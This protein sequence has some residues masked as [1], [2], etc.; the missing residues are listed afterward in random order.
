MTSEVIRPDQIVTMALFMAVL[1]LGWLVVK[2]NK[3]GL[4]R[5]IHQG[6]RLKL[7]EVASLSPTD[8][9]MILEA[10]GRSFLLIRCKGAAPVIQ[11]IGLAPI[12]AVIPAQP[13]A[14][15]AQ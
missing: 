15:V 8:R 12:P 1:A 10:D 2:L 11:E 6:K 7:A 14:E 4:S 13:M 9:A 5:R 3:G